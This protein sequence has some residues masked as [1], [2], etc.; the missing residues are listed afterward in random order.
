M[1]ADGV[2][3]FPQEFA[4]V[5]FI[6]K[7]VAALVGTCLLISHMAR[8]SETASLGQT[9]R[10]LTLLYLAVLI[11]SAS[12]EQVSQ[13][14]EVYYRNLAVIPGIVLLIVAAAVSLAEARRR[15]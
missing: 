9:L 4:H 15:R 14:A 1:I 8:K 2:S 5:F 13:D 3:W 11:T 10:Y 7:G 12:V 6:L